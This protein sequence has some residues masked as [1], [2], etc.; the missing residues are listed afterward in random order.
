MTGSNLHQH[1]HCSIVDE[2]RHEGNV[3]VVENLGKILSTLFHLVLASWLLS[4]IG[5]ETDVERSGER[6]VRETPFSQ[7]HNSKRPYV[8]AGFIVREVVDNAE[9]V[10]RSKVRDESD[11]NPQTRY[12]KK[13]LR[14]CHN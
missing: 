4:C 8:E 5:R 13:C 2:G 3:G 6:A 10:P 9:K 7:F 1:E 11:Q 14:Q 12:H